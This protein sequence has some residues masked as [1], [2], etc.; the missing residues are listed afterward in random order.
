M[1]TRV[2]IIVATHKKYEMPKDPMY[3]PLHVG[4]E[5]KFDKNGNALDFGYQKDNDGDNISAKNYCFGSQTGLYWGWKHID[6]DYIGLVHY[7]RQFLGKKMGKGNTMDCVLTEKQLLPMLDTYTVFVPRKRR[8]YIES[9]YSHY[10]HTM[11]R[12]KEQFDTVREILNEK[13]PEYLRAF[14]TVMKRTWA[15]MFNLMILR[16]DLMDSYCAWLFD[17]LF[18]LERRIDT[19]GMSAFD[20]RFC[21]RV[22]ERL[23]DVWLQRQI[24]AGIVD[25]KKI[26]ELPYMEEVKWSTKV[27]SFVEAK[28]FHKKY[29]ASF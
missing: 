1:G 14:D 17:V 28:L 29:G 25:E 12:G 9:I 22:S 11:N 8:Y 24:E 3:F 13:Y 27:K 18:E 23:F 2:K 15:Y 10:S 6:A 16:K 19:T 20:K 26:K 4:A 5:G 7:R 21:G